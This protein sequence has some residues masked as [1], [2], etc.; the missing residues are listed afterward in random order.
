MEIEIRSLGEPQQI[1]QSL[2]A[3]LAHALAETPAERTFLSSQDGRISW[4]A[5]SDRLDAA[6]DAMLALGLRQG[7]RVVIGL[8]DEIAESCLFLACLRAGITA[9]M[10]DRHATPDAIQAL[11]EAASPRAAWLRPDFAALP[12]LR[13]IA[14]P[15]PPSQPVL[16]RPQWP[17]TPPAETIAAVVFT[18]GTT[19]RPKGVQISHRALAAQMEAFAEVYG[20]G[21]DTRMLNLLPLHH[22]DGLFRGLVAAAVH[23]AEL[24]RPA[25]FTIQGLPALRDTVQRERITHFIAV[26]TM[27]ALILRLT[28]AGP[29]RFAGPDLRCVISS[30]D[31]LDADLWH[32]AEAGFG[33]PVMNAWGQSE[34]VCD[35]LYAVPKQDGSHIGTIGRPVGC[36]A[37]VAD[38]TGAEVSDGKV[39]ELQIRGPLVMSGYL[40]Q[41]DATAAAMVDGWLRTGDLVT[42][43]TTGIYRFVGRRNLVIVSRGVSVHPENIVAALLASEDV[44]E[45]FVLG[46]P[47]PDW[48]ERILACVVAAAGHS[49]SLLSLN[50]VCREALP[51]E[52][53]PHSIL[54]LDELPRGPAGKVRIE[55]L[56]AL[57]AL[58]ETTPPEAAPL[59]VLGVAATC[60]KVAPETL[61][62]QSTPFNTHDWDSLG[63]I[64]FIEALEAA[65][66][67]T[68]AP[69]D[70]I[71]L[72]SIA[73]AEE[74][75]ARHM[76]RKAG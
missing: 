11:V 75:V 74:I 55:A 72:A 70:I 65:F 31:H 20:F 14:A 45:A 54:I 7:D 51:P 10:A 26:P 50:E 63:H 57:I 2:T 32:R 43:D 61:S 25:A 5:L 17:A 19:S 24:H 67:I 37:R 41:P 62:S 15:V 39:G 27:L 42:R 48:G 12:A 71:G 16:P 33:L 60:F 28:E 8:G 3:R 56:R 69:E 58:R 13:G 68:L 1:G 64:I 23:G 44:A 52:K 34:C 38:E 35:A 30:A 36:E 40:D 76:A 29:L 4:G 66:A 22:V 21:P 47:D 53:R 49:P 18:S 59:S 9:V 73:D 46:L 6:L